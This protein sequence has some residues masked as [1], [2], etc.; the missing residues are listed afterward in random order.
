MIIV[1]NVPHYGE[2]RVYIPWGKSLD[3]DNYLMIISMAYFLGS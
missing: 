2:F 3:K 1:F